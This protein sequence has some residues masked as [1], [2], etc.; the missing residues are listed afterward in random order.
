VIFEITKREL[1]DPAKFEESKENLRQELLNQRQAAMV[2][3]AL[4]GLRESYEIEIN[5]EIVSRIDT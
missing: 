2:E 4:N 1:F 3:A 5:A